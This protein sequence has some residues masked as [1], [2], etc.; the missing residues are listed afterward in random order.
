MTVS[1]NEISFPD[2][3]RNRWVPWITLLVTLAIL[4]VIYAPT[5]LTDITG[6]VEVNGVQDP[7]M[8]DVG[9]IQ[10]ALNIWGTLHQSGYAL[11]RILGNMARIPLRALGVN[12]ATAPV[13]FSTLC[14]LIALSIFF[15]LVYRLTGKAEVAAAAML[16]LG[17][18]Q[19]IWVHN[20]IA[21]VR[22]L[23][24]AFEVG[25]LAVALWSPVQTAKAGQNRILLLAL[26]GGFGVAHHRTVGLMLPGLLIAVWAG[27]RALGKRLWLILGVALLVGMIGF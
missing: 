20:V 24:F 13:L 19:T 7:Y 6:G 11:Y 12:A 23:S 8:Q 5:M 21:S 2:S 25:L 14:G 18:T 17:V 10:V 3:T 15:A 1:K 26:I 4:I 9:E 16:L 22:S 27:L